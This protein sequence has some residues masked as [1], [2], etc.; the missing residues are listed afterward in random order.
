MKENPL[1]ETIL[2]N[3]LQQ[4]SS[5]ASSIVTALVGW[6]GF[7]FIGPLMFGFKMAPGIQV[8][9]AV[10]SAIVQVIILRSLFFVL[11][12][13]RHILIGAFWGLVSVLLMY[14]ITSIIYPPLK[15]H[16]FAWMLNYAYIGTPVGGFLSYFY[17]DDKKIFDATGGQQPDT[18]FGRDAHWLEPFAFGA[19]AYL[20]V[21][22]PFAHFDL[23]INTLIVGAISG[24]AAA[25][26]SHFSPD[27]WK[28]SIVLL[29][30]IIIGLGG[31]QGFITGFLLRSYA[32]ELY[33]NYLILGAASGILTYLMTFARGR[34]LA[35]KE[36]KGML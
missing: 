4:R 17:I 36:E 5:W 35:A 3:P 1:S 11:Q 14:Y 28:K 9:L 24:V 25:G 30:I 16:A 13:H 23:T 10:S 34:Q 15:D 2:M 20:L 12:M 18:N 27:K 29:A 32:D 33:A 6:L 26:A 8:A 7:V 31:V 21:C 22:F 19:A